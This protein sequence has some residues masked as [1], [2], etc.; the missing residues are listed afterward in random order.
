[1]DADKEIVRQFLQTYPKKTLDLDVL[2]AVF[3]SWE[4]SRFQSAVA[5][6]LPDGRMDNAEAVSSASISLS[7]TAAAS[8]KWPTR[9]GKSWYR[10]RKSRRPFLKNTIPKA[11]PA[12][13]NTNNWVF[14][15]EARAAKGKDVQK[16]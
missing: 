15:E 4:Y 11:W 13:T 7:S 8:P 1:M 5:A 9:R 6:L 10:I 14:S 3:A 12:S 2:Q 16:R